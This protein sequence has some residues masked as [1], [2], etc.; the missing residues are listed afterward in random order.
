MSRAGT[1]GGSQSKYRAGEGSNTSSRRGSSSGSSSSSELATVYAIRDIINSA[2][3]MVISYKLVTG[4]GPTDKEQAAFAGLLQLQLFQMQ[5][6]G[7]H[8]PCSS[9]CLC[10]DYAST[11]RQLVRAC[12]EAVSAAGSRVDKRNVRDAV[13]RG[14]PVRLRSC[15]TTAGHR[16]DAVQ[17]AL[18][19]FRE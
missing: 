3:T 15:C 7:I 1:G 10:A 12:H 9:Q 19:A 5:M 4:M 11:M 18:M 17:E 13:F 8:G 14:L 2:R 16:L 6:A